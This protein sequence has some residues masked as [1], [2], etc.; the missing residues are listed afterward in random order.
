MTI[1]RTTQH[2]LAATVAASAFSLAACGGADPEPETGAIDPVSQED[3]GTPPVPDEPTTPLTTIPDDAEGSDEPDV[4][5]GVVTRI[6]DGIPLG[7]DLWDGRGDGGEYH[8]TPYHPAADEERWPIAPCG[9]EVWPRPDTVE[10]LWAWA[11][12]PEYAD[13]RAIVTLPSVDSAVAALADIRAALEACP[14]DGTLVW[15]PHAI[16]T[17]Y[18]SV[19]F[20]LSYDSLGLHTYLVTRVANAILLTDRYGEGHIS[21]AE[22]GARAQVGLTRTLASYLCVFSEAGC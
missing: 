1:R 13:R 14:E 10:E 7:Q 19:V 4:E 20:S 2:L 18:D 21:Y 12:G 8:P 16:D 22:E 15:T 11:T 9:V 6:P 17:G 5:A 3:D